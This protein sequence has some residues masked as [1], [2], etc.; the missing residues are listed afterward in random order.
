MV[1]ID[2]KK[3][4]E[5]KPKQKPISRV[6]LV[7]ETTPAPK[8]KRVILIPPED[9]DT[10]SAPRN[11]VAPKELYNELRQ[12]KVDREAL[13]SAIA[14]K[15]REFE[16]GKI[17]GSVLDQLYDDI[18]QYTKEGSAV[19]QKIEHYERYGEMPP[20]PEEQKPAI[21]S[22]NIAELKVRKRS[23]ENM[24]NKITKKI[25]LAR[26]GTQKPKNPMKVAEWEMQLLEYDKE[27]QDIRDKI[28]NLDNV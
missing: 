23:L 25:E 27:W 11:K 22:N 24:R 21:E 16:A 6:Q 15:V 8:P 17:D 3:A 26:K 19:Y 2:V 5:A 4:L 28:N 7:S 9:V 12:I 14:E 18:E 20:E 10:T 1:I 13:S